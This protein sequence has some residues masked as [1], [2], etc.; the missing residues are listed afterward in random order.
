MNIIVIKI[1]HLEDVVFLKK[2]NYKIKN[3][4]ALTSGDAV[5]E[6]L[7]PSLVSITLTF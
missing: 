1:T 6:I 2:T 7:L 4:M 3:L 5:W